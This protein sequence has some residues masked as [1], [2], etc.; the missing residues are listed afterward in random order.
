MSYL[1][2]LEPEDLSTLAAALKRYC[3]LNVVLPNT[4]EW[5]VLA[6]RA[7]VLFHMGIRTFDEIALRLADRPAVADSAAL[8]EAIRPSA[9]LNGTFSTS[10]IP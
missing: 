3:D 8:S 5:D 4:L 1:D 6:Q 10:D 9:D 7:L 2:H